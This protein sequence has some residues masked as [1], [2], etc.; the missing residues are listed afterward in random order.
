MYEYILKQNHD[1]LNRVAMNYYG[2]NTTYG[3]MFQ[4]IDRMAG[5]LQAAGIGVGEAVTV[6]MVNGPDTGCL[7]FALNKIDAVA[8]MVYGADTSEELLTHL[9]YAHSKP[10]LRWICFWINSL[11]L[12]TKHIL[13]VLSSQTSLWKWLP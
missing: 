13:S 2:A 7:L 4:R 12:L 1:N 10:Y 3:K 11:P 9:T 6:C 5:S 8:N